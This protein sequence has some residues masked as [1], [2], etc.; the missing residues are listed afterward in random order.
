MSEDT[1]VVLIIGGILVVLMGFSL[2]AQVGK[3]RA[4]AAQACY[5]AAKVNHN[6]KCEVG[7]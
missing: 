4:K 6:I 3:D 1:K 5:E 7:K 2:S